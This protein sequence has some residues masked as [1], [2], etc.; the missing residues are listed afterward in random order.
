[1][2]PTKEWLEK[3]NIIKEK[4]I[5]PVDLNTYFEQAEI[6]GKQLTVMDIGI[7][8]LPSGKVLVRDPLVYLGIRSEQPY[9][10]AAPAGNYHTEVCVIKPDKE[11]DCARYAAVRLRFSDKRPVGFYEALIG[12]ENIEELGDDEY[13]GFNVDAGLGCI[14]DEVVHQAFCDWSEQWDREHPKGNQYDDYFAALFAENYKANPEFQRNGGDWL[15]W[16]IPGTQYR[17]PMFQS[18]FGDGAYPV[19]WG[20]DENGAICQLVVQLIDIQLAYGK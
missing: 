9:F 10:Q 11:G 18:G 5:S 14:C 1:M 17:L 8:S 7:C 12:I 15:N 4:T 20:F 19:Y 3:W 16:Q 2:A 6:A 13:F